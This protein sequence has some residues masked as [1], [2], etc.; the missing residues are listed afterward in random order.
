MSHLDHQSQS[1]IANTTQVFPQESEVEMELPRLSNAFTQIEDSSPAAITEDSTPFFFASS[2]DEGGS[3][4]YNKRDAEDPRSLF[5]ADRFKV[6]FNKEALRL[7]NLLDTNGKGAIS[8]VQL[9]AGMQTLGFTKKHA[10]A[11]LL[12]A[13]AN[14]SSSNKAPV[15][16]TSAHVIS[17]NL[18]KKVVRVHMCCTLL[19]NHFA[20]AAEAALHKQRQQEE[21]AGV[22]AAAARRKP[23]IL[24]PKDHMLTVVDY[25]ATEICL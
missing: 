20:R 25:S 8:S 23:K 11:A 18:F 13:L 15:P 3:E 21:G 10:D 14:Q 4:Q 2:E 5:F 22:P 19:D 1:S 6:R 12:V 16:P 17:L 7:F 9:E 24:A